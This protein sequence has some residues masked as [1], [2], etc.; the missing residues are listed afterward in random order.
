M[1]LKDF[2]IS[3]KAISNDLLLEKDKI[4]RIGVPP[5]RIK[6]I[7]GASGVDFKEC[8]SRRQ[9]IDIDGIPVS[10]ISLQDL[11]ANKRAA[12]RHKDMEDLD[13]LP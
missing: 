1:A 9:V 2:G 5:V 8:Y 6:I 4:I 7:T 12:G 13:H 11:K 10:F 3:Q